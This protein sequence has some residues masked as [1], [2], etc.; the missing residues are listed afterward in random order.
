MLFVR[1]CKL[2]DNWHCI[3][4]APLFNELGTRLKNQSWAYVRFHNANPQKSDY[5]TVLAAGLR[6][7]DQALQLQGTRGEVRWGWSLRAILEANISGGLNSK[8]LNLDIILAHCPHAHR[9]NIMS[10]PWCVRNSTITSAGGDLG[11][12][13]SSNPSATLA[14]KIIEQ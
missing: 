9:G 12:L 4:K 5:R 1:E 2:I 13:T 7:R 8:P 10:V 14:Q 11:G 6:V 3:P